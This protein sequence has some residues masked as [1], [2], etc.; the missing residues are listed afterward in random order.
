MVLAHG[1]ILMENQREPMVASVNAFYE[2]CG[3][4]DR[5]RAA[6]HV[7][8][9]ERHEQPWNQVDALAGQ[10]QRHLLAEGV[11]LDV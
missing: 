2:N 7:A 6:S 9:D 8:L 1:A 11:A 10:F 3:L 4:P 5:V